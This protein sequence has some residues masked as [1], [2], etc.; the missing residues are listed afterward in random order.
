[1]SRKEECRRNERQEMIRSKEDMS[2]KEESGSQ[3][4]KKKLRV[5]YE[6]IPISNGIIKMPSVHI[7]GTAKI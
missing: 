6:T 2:R 7:N 3:E 1:M 5:G 4:M